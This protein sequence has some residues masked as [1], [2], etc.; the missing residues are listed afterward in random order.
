MAVGRRVPQYGLPQRHRRALVS[1]EYQPDA[2]FFNW[3]A[4]RLQRWMAAGNLD[5]LVRNRIRR[6]RASPRSRARGS[7]ACSDLGGLVGCVGVSA[8]FGADARRGADLGQS[9]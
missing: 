8:V 1:G 9:L 5:D 3:T 6:R 4:C 2:W 7:I